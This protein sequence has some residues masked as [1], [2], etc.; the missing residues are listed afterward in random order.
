M[1]VDIPNHIHHALHGE[2]ADLWKTVMLQEIGQLNKLEV[3]EP[4]DP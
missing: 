4:I 1:D 2:H 3:W